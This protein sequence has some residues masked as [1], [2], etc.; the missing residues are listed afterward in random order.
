M[1]KP[2]KLYENTGS[3]LCH[4]EKNPRY[5]PAFLRRPLRN[6]CH[7][8]PSCSKSAFNQLW[9][10]HCIKSSS[11]RSLSAPRG[12]TPQPTDPTDHPESYENES[13]Y[14]ETADRMQSLSL[15]IPLA[16][17]NKNTSALG[18]QRSCDSLWTRSESSGD[19][20]Q[21]KRTPPPLHNL[22]CVW[23]G[24]PPVKRHPL[25]LVSVSTN[26]PV[27]I[28]G[29]WCANKHLIRTWSYHQWTRDPVDSN[30]IPDM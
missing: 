6:K 10:C 14:H 18:L 23:I 19:R 30:H 3:L 22:L 29:N 21:K 17:R 27:G 11:H 25:N 5:K 28:P 4:D 16:Y 20:P 1:E 2:L 13:F 8:H 15:W 9:I 7:L 24:V 26:I 12:S